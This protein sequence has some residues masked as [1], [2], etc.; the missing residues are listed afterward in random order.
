LKQSF[1]AIQINLQVVVAGGNVVG[2]AVVGGN[3]EGAIVLVA[4]VVVAVA[5]PFK[6]NH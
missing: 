2:A 1:V 4:F 3:V 5:A 6:T